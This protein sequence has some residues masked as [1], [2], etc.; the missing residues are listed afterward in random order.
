MGL[1]KEVEESPE[2]SKHAGWI[3]EEGGMLEENV[4]GVME[5]AGIDAAG[6]IMEG[7][8]V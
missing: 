5:V 7:E 4:C 1:E 8:G 2:V 3:E 6:K